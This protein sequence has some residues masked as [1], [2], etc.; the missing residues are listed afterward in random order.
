MLTDV[1]FRRYENV[2]IASSFDERFRALISQATQ[3]ITKQIFPTYNYDGKINQQSKSAMTDVHDRICMEMGLDAL[4][5]K[6]FST[7]ST[8]NG[9]TTDQWHEL[10]M[11]DVIRNFMTESFSETYSPDLYIKFRLSVIEL[12]FRLREQQIQFENAALPSKMIEA[13]RYK[14][15]GRAIRLPGKASDGVKALNQQINDTFRAN[16]DELNERF[17][18]SGLKL[19][20][21]NGFIQGS[22]DVLAQKQ[23]EFPF[24]NICADAAFA[25]VDTDMKQAVELRDTKG[26]DPAW[27]AAR[28]LE[29]AI[30]IASNR[31]GCT[32]GNEKG[33]HNFIDNLLGARGGKFFE[34]WEAEALKAFFTKVRNP[35]GHGPGEG[36]MPSLTSL[37]TDYAIEHCMSWVKSILRRL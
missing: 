14:P 4:G 34:V 10:P 21:H 26:R 13:D 24:W 7:K 23:I 8:W 9:N 33:V 35:F 11:G 28:A 17:R 15:V 22:D 6:W 3:I 1:F 25:N 2:V 31:R 37:Q 5:S 29:S 12:A 20:Y 16:V 32:T 19:H 30:K 18:Q 36:P 27:Y